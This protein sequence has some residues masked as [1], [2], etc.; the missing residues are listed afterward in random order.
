MRN[1]LV[2]ISILIVSLLYFI[3][4]TPV[5]LATEKADRRSKVWPNGKEVNLTVCIGNGESHY[6]CRSIKICLA[7]QKGRGGEQC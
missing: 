7:R 6:H 1:V 5:G 3:G 2:L 4:L